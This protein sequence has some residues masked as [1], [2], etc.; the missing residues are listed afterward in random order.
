V[1][2]LEFGE[3][4]KHEMNA[5]GLSTDERLEMVGKC[6]LDIKVFG[7]PEN[8]PG[9][10]I[11]FG[12]PGD[13]KRSCYPLQP[14]EAALLIYD[15]LRRYKK[16][17]QAQEA[18]AKRPGGIRITFDEWM[19]KVKGGRKKDDNHPNRSREKTHGTVASPQ[20][21]KEAVKEPPRRVIVLPPSG[22]ADKAKH[23][24]DLL[25]ADFESGDAW[26]VTANKELKPLCDLDVIDLPSE[27]VAKLRVLSRKLR[28]LES[29]L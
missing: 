8:K 27:M 24:S 15:Y 6:Q 7:D 22:I 17:E 20:V 19:S 25:L 14:A 23:V 3:K 10:S 21:V 11:V 4:L 26:C 1:S 9:G 2:E 29:R 13:R 5:L 12:F 18:V 16:L 28:E